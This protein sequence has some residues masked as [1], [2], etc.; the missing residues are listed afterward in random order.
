MSPGEEDPD[1]ELDL[2]DGGLSALGFAAL[3]NQYELFDIKAIKPYL[4]Q[5]GMAEIL[6]YVIGPNSTSILASILKRGL[7]PN[8]NGRGGSSAIQRCLECFCQYGGY[9]RHSF[10]YHHT[11]F[12]DS[13]A[14]NKEL[15]SERSREFM[16]MIYLLADAGGKWR[17]DEDDIKS[18]RKSLNKMKG[19]YTVEFISL[20]AR[21]QA[22]SREDLE[23]LIRTPTIKK[24]IGKYRRRIDEQLGLIEHATR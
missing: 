6:D 12:G 3:Y 1:R 21:F 7:D 11:S 24:I 4:T 20:M 15:D 16:K 18:A 17:P 23:E 19:E 2:E 14:K 10:D 8:N 9:S 13:G 22:A 5:P